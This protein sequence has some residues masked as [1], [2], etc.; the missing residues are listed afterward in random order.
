MGCNV[1]WVTIPPYFRPYKPLLTNGFFCGI[2]ILIKGLDIELSIK[3]V[4]LWVTLHFGKIREVY[5]SKNWFLDYWN[6]MCNIWRNFVDTVSFPTRV[7]R[8]AHLLEPL[9]KLHTVKKMFIVKTFQQKRENLFNAWQFDWW[10]VFMSFWIRK[11]YLEW[12]YES[13]EPINE[14]PVG[15]NILT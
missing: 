8:I 7:I 13:S 6:I 9:C 15:L 14:Q 3:W 5:I 4:I 11:I 12:I 2:K 10:P 1:Q